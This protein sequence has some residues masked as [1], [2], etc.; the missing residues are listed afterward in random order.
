MG[1]DADLEAK[2]R[3]AIEDTLRIAAECDTAQKA[4]RESDQVP[5]PLGHGETL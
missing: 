2:L 1:S 5:K 3:K 4:P